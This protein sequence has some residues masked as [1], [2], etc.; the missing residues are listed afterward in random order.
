[1]NKQSTYVA[2]LNHYLKRNILL[3]DPIW[4]NKPL[5]QTKRSKKPSAPK[6]KKQST[7]ATHLK[8][9][10]IGWLAAL[11]LSSIFFSHFEAEKCSKPCVFHIFHLWEAFSKLHHCVLR[12]PIQNSDH[13]FSLRRNMFSQSHAGQQLLFTSTSTIHIY[14]HIYLSDYLSIYPNILMYPCCARYVQG[15]QKETKEEH[16]ES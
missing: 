12:G 14:I 5:T 13:T 3:Y 6:K 10:G 16:V 7:Y 2:R 1:M 11:Q 4:C 15:M 9:K 8:N